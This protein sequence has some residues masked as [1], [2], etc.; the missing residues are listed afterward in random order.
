MKKISLL[1]IIVMMI[2][3]EGCS[4]SKLK[5]IPK[6]YIKSEE[7][8]DKDGM[9]DYSDYAKYIYDNEEV[10]T[11]N[12]EYKEITIDDI[13]NVVGYFDDFYGVI[14]LEGIYDFDTSII[15]QGDYVRIKTKEGEKIGNSVYGKYDNY[16]VY[17]FDKESLTLYYIH[18]NI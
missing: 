17:F 5:D 16:S 18:N 8:F 13:D 11:N 2:M 15:T 14:K 12:K 3:T 4:N 6:G 9:Q 7:H 10:I 1:I